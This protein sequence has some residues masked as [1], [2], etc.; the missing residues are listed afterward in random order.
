MGKRIFSR[1]GKEYFFALLPSNRGALKSTTRE[2][3]CI[4]EKENTTRLLNHMNS[5][6]ALFVPSCFR[7][8]ERKAKKRGSAKS[9]SAQHE[10]KKA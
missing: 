8:H 4:F 5:A 9:K 1:Y 3:A 6:P 7:V 2:F 10:T